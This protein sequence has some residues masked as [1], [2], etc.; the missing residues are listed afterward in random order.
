LDKDKDKEKDKEKTMINRRLFVLKIIAVLVWTGFVMVGSAHAANPARYSIDMRYN[1]TEPAISED[2]RADKKM[3]GTLIAVAEFTD[4][5][6]VADKKVIGWVKEIDGSK[7]PVFPKQEIPAR[8]IADGIKEYLQKAGYLVAGEMVQWDLKE[9]TLPK[10]KGKVIIGGA[11]EVLEASC[12]T[13]VFSND[14]KVNLKLHLVVAD[15]AKRKI[16]YKGNVAVDSSKT[17]VSFSEAYFGYLASGALNEAIAKAFEG[18]TVA[19]KLR[20]AILQ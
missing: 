2:L 11:I 12:W 3:R 20:E 16:L 10:G 4:M 9:G 6:S 19:Q 8:A 5:R 13:G 17:D 14:Y 18:K 7:V 1:L 15:A